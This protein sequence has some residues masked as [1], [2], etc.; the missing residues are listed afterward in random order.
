M[1]I[2]IENKILIPFMVLIILSILVIMV[3][4]YVNSYNMILENET[5]NYLYDLN[6]MIVFMEEINEDFPEDQPRAQD[7]IIEFYD[8]AGKDG[9]I[10]F[11]NVSREVLLDNSGVSNDFINNLINKKLSRDKEK[12]SEGD[13]IFIYHIY[14][15]Y[16]W[17]I[18]YRLNKKTFFYSVLES[19]KNM[20]LIAIVAMVFSMQSAILISYNISKPIK[21][22]ADYCDKIA[23][24]DN[25]QE[26]IEINRKDEI[27]TL[28]NAFNNMLD[29]LQGNTEKIIEITRFNEDILKNIKAGII[30]TDRYGNLLSANESAKKLIHEN[31]EKNLDVDI[32]EKLLDQAGCTLAEDKVINNIVTFNDTDGSIIYLDVTTSLLK[33][34]KSSKD[35]AICSFNDISDR[36]KFE[37][38]MDL[39][40]RL[41]SIGQFAAGIAHEIRNPLTGMKTSIQVLENRFCKNDDLSNKKLFKGVV[42]EID[43][44]NDLIS[45]LLNFAKPRVPRYERTDLCEVLDAAMEL[46][47]KSATENNINISVRADCENTVVFADKT[48]IEQIFLNIIKNAI[49]AVEKQGFINISFVN[50]CNENGNY[51]EVEF[52][53]N[54]CGINPEDLTKIFDPFFTTRNQGTGLGLSVVYELV[55]NNRGKI[56]VQSVVNEGTR[57]K[58]EFPEYGG[59][60]YEEKDIDC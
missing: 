31:I 51:V 10:I 22:L 41:T 21:K 2:D 39:L 54:G 24:G 4:S 59:K 35:G 43:R 29:R 23:D 15:R 8:K 26:R 33:G 14:D 49:S 32:M 56:A 27:G 48:Q 30:T 18:G 57:V 37:N 13:Y 42:H 44:I 36:K 16:N 1:K 25:T 50:G 45:G 60:K 40:D 55:K 9:L 12:V 11:N 17:T 20:I 28:S 58:I 53:D 47:K 7:Y 52:H 5:K 3:M 34:A 38:N 19:E 46:I 6:E